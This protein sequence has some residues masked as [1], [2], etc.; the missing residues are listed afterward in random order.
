MTTKISTYYEAVG[1]RKTSTARARLTPSTKAEI[2][3]NGVPVATYFT[4]DTHRRTVMEAFHVSGTEQVFNVSVH[5]L[6]GGIASQSGAVRH[7]IARAL[8]AFAGTLR[9]PL[10]SAGLLTRDPRMKERRKFGLRKA[11]RAPQWSKR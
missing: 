10:K 4:L 8:T 3:I 7:A 5:V 1:R 11:R 6:G 9:S 2:T